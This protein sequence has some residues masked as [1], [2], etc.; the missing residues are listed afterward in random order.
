MIA[1]ENGHADVIEILIENGGDVNA[2]G[3]QFAENDI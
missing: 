2:K 1:A 3:M